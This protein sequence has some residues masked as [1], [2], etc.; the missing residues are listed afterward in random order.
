MSVVFLWNGSIHW[1]ETR[2]KSGSVSFSVGKSGWVWSF[3]ARNW[4]FDR[5]LASQRHGWSRLMR[6]KDLTR[7]HGRKVCTSSSKQLLSHQVMS[8]NLDRR[9]PAFIFEDDL[10]PL[11]RVHTLRK[12]ILKLG[13]SE[14]DSLMEGEKRG[15]H[16][17]LWKMPAEGGERSRFD[18]WESSRKPLMEAEGTEPGE[19]IPSHSP[20]GR[21][22]CSNDDR[23]SPSH[24]TTAWKSQSQE[25][26]K[27]FCFCWPEI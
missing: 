6:V 17:A 22:I 5:F 20:S 19:Q 15:E 1:R 21:K 9:T 18:V 26:I 12:H 3:A 10:L 23:T 27:V 16:W 7:K 4:N 13:V 14:A 8:S 24:G 25:S 2:E 11:L